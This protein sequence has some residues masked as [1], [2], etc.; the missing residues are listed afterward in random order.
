MA[1]TSVGVADGSNGSVGEGWDDV[2]VGAGSVVAGG[3][4]SVGVFVGCTVAFASRSR[5]MRPVSRAM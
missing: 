4:G 1:A 3:G 5:W 2:A